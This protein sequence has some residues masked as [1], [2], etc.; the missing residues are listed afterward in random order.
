MFTWLNFVVAF[1]KYVHGIRNLYSVLAVKIERLPIE[2]FV[3][4]WEMNRQFLTVIFCMGCK[5]QSN[6]V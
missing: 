3:M 6:Q 1:K 2:Q 5:H 4:E